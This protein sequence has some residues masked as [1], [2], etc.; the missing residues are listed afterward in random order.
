M[1]QTTISRSDL[2][3]A[4]S[5]AINLTLKRVMRELEELL[6]KVKGSVPATNTLYVAMD[7]ISLLTVEK[8]EEDIK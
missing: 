3:F 6:P 1:T 8:I 5:A 7:R 4:T 2:D